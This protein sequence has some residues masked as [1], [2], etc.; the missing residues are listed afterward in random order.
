MKT[1]YGIINMLIGG[2]M[3]AAMVPEKMPGA[4]GYLFRFF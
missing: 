2:H 4:L 1:I 3:A